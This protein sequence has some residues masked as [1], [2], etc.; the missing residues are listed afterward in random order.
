M[1]NVQRGNSRVANILQ[2]MDQ[3]ST[4]FLTEILLIM[5]RFWSR[6]WVSALFV[7]SFPVFRLLDLSQIAFHLT[8]RE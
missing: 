5:L 6:S 4:D 7:P 8:V 3:F 1:L 2:A